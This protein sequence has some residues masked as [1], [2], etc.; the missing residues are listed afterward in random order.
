MILRKN[1]TTSDQAVTLIEKNS[2]SQLSRKLKKITIS[3]NSDNP[4]TVIVDLF[5]G[6]ST[7]FYICKNIIIPKGV[8][9]VLE[10]NLVFKTENFNLRIY[11][12][13]SNP[14]LTIMI[15]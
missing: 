5:D 7:V 8:I 3:N 6:S 15:S 10:D 1:I 14:D 12:T 11:N 4:A 2:N 9:L 13:G